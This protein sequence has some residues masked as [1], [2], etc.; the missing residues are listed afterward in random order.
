MRKSR[1]HW[2]HFFGRMSIVCC[3]P[4]V[5]I[6]GRGLASGVVELKDRRTA[7]REEVPVGD[8]VERIAVHIV[9]AP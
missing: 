7:E 1:L 6:V 8:V 9:A 5:M 3:T 4:T 2:S